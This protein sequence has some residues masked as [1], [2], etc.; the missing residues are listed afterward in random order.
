MFFSAVVCYCSDH[1]SMC[2]V[3]IKL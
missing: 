2:N 1:V 3:L